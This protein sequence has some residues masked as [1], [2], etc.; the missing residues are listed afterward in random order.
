MIFFSESSA[1]TKRLGERIGKILL[2]GDVVALTGEL[3]S[4]KTVLTKGI[5]RGLKIKGNPVRSPSFVLIKEY[6]GKVP[7]FHFDLYRLKKQ[8]ELNTLGYEEYFSGKGVVVIEW[9]ERA[10]NF[11]P[12]EY[13]EIK[14]SIL[15]KDERRISLTAKGEGLKKRLKRILCK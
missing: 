1:E 6:P 15:G 11:L 5:A 3:G 13:L 7:I 12:D 10:K 4:G 2:P 8:N 14:L 9:A